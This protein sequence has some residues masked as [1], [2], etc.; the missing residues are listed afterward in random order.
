MGRK[1]VE[2]NT[3]HGFT[4]DQLRKM[5]QETKS[6]YSRNVLLAVI[7]RFQGISTD[8]IM[9]VLGKSRATITSYINSWNE[10]PVSSVKDHRGGNI[11]SQL[12]DEIIQ[13][14]KDIVMH[15]SPTD[16]DYPQSKW[17]SE[18]LTQY[19]EETYGKKFCSRWIRKLLT[20]LGFS[21]KRGIYYPTKADPVAQ[22]QFKK[23]ED[24]DGYY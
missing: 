8:E 22:E 7:M 23:N 14:I 15:K 3:L 24:F 20:N 19:I 2:V 13:D 16:F 6:S 21:Y 11:P 18:L 1:F 12:T 5:S 4:I 17:S 10:N 9:S